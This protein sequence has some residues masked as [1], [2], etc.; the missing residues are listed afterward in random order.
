MEMIKERP[1]F[2]VLRDHHPLLVLLIEG[3][4]HVQEDVRVPQT[5]Q[6]LDLL[7]EALLED[8]SLNLVLLLIIAL[9][10]H[11]LGS[12]E[13]KK[14]LSKTTLGEKPQFLDLIAFYYQ[15]LL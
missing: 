9:D 12:V 1:V 4:P 10:G 13:S 7:D 6:D 15:M 14:D 11:L 2:E 3:H 5:A 8:L